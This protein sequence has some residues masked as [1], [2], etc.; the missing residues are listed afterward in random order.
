MCLPTMISQTYTRLVEFP[1][2]D[3]KKFKKVLLTVVSYGIKTE[4]YSLLF[5]SKPFDCI[6]VINIVDHIFG[7]F[8]TLECSI[9]F[10]DVH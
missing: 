8:K 9:N 7:Q 10:I 2:E 6:V 4:N 5:N 3:R 1:N